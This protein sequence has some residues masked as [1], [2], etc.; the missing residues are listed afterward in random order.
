MPLNL[1]SCLLSPV[2][3]HRTSNKLYENISHLG[4]LVGI[5]DTSLFKL[6]QYRYDTNDFW[7]YWYLISI[8]IPVSLNCLAQFYF[9]QLWKILKTG[10]GQLCKILSGTQ[11]MTLPWSN[12]I[13]HTSRKKFSAIPNILPEKNFHHKQPAINSAGSVSKTSDTWW[14]YLPKT[15]KYRQC[16]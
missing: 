5:G 16:R 3:E 12:S 2:L 13:K 4:S 11:P 10:F 8:P 1:F 7:W 15:C 9:G 14:Q 6:I